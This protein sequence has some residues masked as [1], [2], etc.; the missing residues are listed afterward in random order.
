MEPRIDKYYYFINFFFNCIYLTHCNRGLFWSIMIL[1]F[2][3]KMYV[4]FKVLM[5]MGICYN[6]LLCPYHISIITHG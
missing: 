6:L 5:G 3:I 1:G 2:Q 4:N